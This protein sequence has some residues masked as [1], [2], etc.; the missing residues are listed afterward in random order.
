MVAL[1][2]DSGAKHRSSVLLQPGPCKRSVRRGRGL[3]ATQDIKGT[4][5]TPLS[6]L[7]ERAANTENDSAGKTQHHGGA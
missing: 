5:P 3:I 6:R 7:V 4:D 2:R 1:P